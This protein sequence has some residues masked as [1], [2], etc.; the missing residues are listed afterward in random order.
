MRFRAVLGVGRNCSLES[1]DDLL[2]DVQKMVMLK[3]RELSKFSCP[4]RLHFRVHTCRGYYGA[5]NCVLVLIEKCNVLET[6]QT[7][8]VNV[9][10]N[11]CKSLSSHW[12]QIT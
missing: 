10:F 7:E 2:F 5:G 1:F 4:N 11:T 8:E 9:L 12:M 3:S 6:Y